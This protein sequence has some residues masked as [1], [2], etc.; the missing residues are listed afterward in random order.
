M[1]EKNLT[2]FKIKCKNYE[3]RKILIIFAAKY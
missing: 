3:K 1:Y 2:H